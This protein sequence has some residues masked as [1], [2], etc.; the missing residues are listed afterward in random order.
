M[1]TQAQQATRKALIG[2]V[3]NLIAGHRN[4]N[5]KVRPMPFPGQPSHYASA[6]KMVRIPPE[7]VPVMTQAGSRRQHNIKQRRKHAFYIPTIGGDF[8][9]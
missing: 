1:A 6:G 9:A 7:H 8:G 3:A 4:P 2:Q 5:P